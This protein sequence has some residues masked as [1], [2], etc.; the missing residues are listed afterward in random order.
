M[1]PA[2]ALALAQSKREPPALVLA[3]TVAV[4]GAGAVSGTDAGP[5]CVPEL[6]PATGCY[7][8][9]AALWQPQRPV[10]VGGIHEFPTRWSCCCCG[11]SGSGSDAGLDAGSV[12]GSVE[13]YV[14]CASPAVP[15]VADVAA[16]GTVVDEAAAAA[17]Y[18]PVDA[19]VV[20]ADHPPR[21]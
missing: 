14:D 15:L 13:N 16:L 6:V 2:L 8:H 5:E 1:A 17:G 12:A 19:T 9:N 18:A 10:R 3:V 11:L 4:S 20:Y 21:P 7:Q